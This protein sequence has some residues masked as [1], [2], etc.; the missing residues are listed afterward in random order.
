MNATSSNAS[1]EHSQSIHYPQLQIPEFDAIREAPKGEI[2]S[3]GATPLDRM[4]TLAQQ[5]DV[6]TDLQELTYRDIPDD[7]PME[8]IDYVHRTFAKRFDKRAEANEENFTTGL[9]YEEYE[10]LFGPDE[11]D[12]IERA[13]FGFASPAELILVRELL[14]MKSIELACLTHPY[15]KNID[16]LLAEMRMSVWYAVDL[17]G[18]EYYDD[19]EPIFKV[20]ESLN[21]TPKIADLS[22]GVLMT[23]KRTIGVLPDGTLIKERSSFVL[24]TDPAS[25][26]DQTIIEKLAVELEEDPT[27]D[28]MQWLED[29]ANIGALAD[30]LLK[31]DSFSL[32]I[33]ISSTIYAF[34]KHTETL[35]ADKKEAKYKERMLQLSATEPESFNAIFT[36]R[37]QHQ[38]EL[39]RI[40]LEGEILNLAVMHYSGPELPGSTT[41]YLKKLIDS[42]EGTTD[43]ES[44]S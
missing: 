40:A 23:R 41:S 33:P 44:Q 8:V 12:M 21:D 1:F 4:T 7:V 35:V 30:A 42:A 31:S 28:W 27:L 39:A 19:P 24:R 15:G 34:N 10:T 9:N 13:R 5:I 18:G 20:K 38:M 26:F 22:K 32:A 14:Q 16:P 37:E 17:Y 6:R 3:Y 36:N 2:K 43:D 11:L 25:S 29:N